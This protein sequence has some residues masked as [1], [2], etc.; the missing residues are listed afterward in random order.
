MASLF[1]SICCILISSYNCINGETFNCTGFE[2]CNN[3]VIK[4]TD[5]EDCTIICANDM[6]LDGATII[7]GHRSNII[8]QDTGT[9]DN[10]NGASYYGA[11]IQ[12]Y[13]ASNLTMIGRASQAFYQTKIVCPMYNGSSNNCNIISMYNGT[14]GAGGFVKVDISSSASF[15][16]VNIKCLDSIN[17]CLYMS[18]D[19]TMYCNPKNA[20]VPF[21]GDSCP[22]TTTDGL[23]WNCHD[24][25]SFCYVPFAP[26]I[27]PTNSPSSAPT[28]SPTRPPSYIPIRVEDN[29][30]PWI[31][32][33]VCCGAVAICINVWICHY[34]LR[35]RGNNGQVFVNGEGSINRLNANSR[36]STN[37]QFQSLL[38][39]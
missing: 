18:G 21:S 12:A 38:G 3:K 10:D 15:R 11:T 28:T 2:S 26:T 35:K 36:R 39:K 27:S 33:V 13:F 23:K 20:S 37:A 31:I 14:H 19:N 5:N 1:I 24:S 32:L 8:M 17:D 22:I 6:P 9:P 7:G 30:N 16:G 34:C 29:I 4:C 25:S